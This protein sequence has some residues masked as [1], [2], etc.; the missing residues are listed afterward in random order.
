MAPSSTD[1]ELAAFEADFDFF[2]R[3]ESFGGFPGEDAETVVDIRELEPE[4]GRVELK[5]PHRHT[6]YAPTEV[7]TLRLGPREST[8]IDAGDVTEGTRLAQRQGRIRIRHL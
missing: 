4:D 6:E 5:N 7:G 1:N 8:V 2:P 3:G